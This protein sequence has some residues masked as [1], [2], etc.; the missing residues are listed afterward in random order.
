MFDKFV[1]LLGVGDN[2]KVDDASNFDTR[3]VN[4]S[5]VINCCT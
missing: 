5:R 3:T 1:G 4:R 2:G